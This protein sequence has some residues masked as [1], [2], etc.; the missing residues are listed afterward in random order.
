MAYMAVKHRFVPYGPSQCQNLEVC[1]LLDRMAKRDVL[2]RN[3]SDVK[4]RT[5]MANWAP[6][7][8]LTRARNL[9]SPQATRSRACQQDRFN[10]QRELTSSRRQL[11]I[12]LRRLCVGYLDG[13]GATARLGY[14]F[15][16]HCLPLCTLTCT[17]HLV[18]FDRRFCF[19]GFLVLTCRRF[20]YLSGGILQAP[21]GEH[22]YPTG[23]GNVWANCFGNSC[24]ALL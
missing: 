20:G 7:R 23:W 8:R 18:L 21:D 4:R 6:G 9:L 14:P 5:S 1:V 3:T 11:I 10:L 17:L 15:A 24:K 13:T 12:A 19:L 16:R 2:D 22:P